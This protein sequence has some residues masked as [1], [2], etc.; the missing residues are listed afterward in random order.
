MFAA[1]VAGSPITD[2]VNS[3]H[4]IYWDGYMTQ[5]WRME[6]Q[7]LRFGESYYNIKDKYL[8][9]SPLVQVEGTNTPILIWTGKTDTNVNWNNSINFFMALKRLGKKSKLLLYEREAHNILEPKHQYHLANTIY[10]WME[11]YLKNENKQSVSQ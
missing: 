1:A 4:D 3:Y 9:N 5:M 7:Q 6:N 10:E 11:E 2:V 8:R